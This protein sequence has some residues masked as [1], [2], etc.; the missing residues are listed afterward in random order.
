MEN[1]TLIIPAKYESESLPNVLEELKRFNYRIC[2]V[3]KNT[4]LK[5]INSIKKF[6]IEIIYQKGYGYGNALIEGIN[7]CKTKYFCI[8]NADGSFDP[9]Y[10]SQLKNK[11]LLNQ[12]FVFCSRYEAGG[13]S[14]DDTILTYIGNKFF[15]G[16][17]NLLFKLKITDVLF[18]YVMGSTKAFKE[19][20]MSFNDFSFCIEL[21][22]KAKK[23]NYIL[24]NLPSVERSRKAGIKKV[25][26]FRD[27][28]LILM[29]IIKLLIFKK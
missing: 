25:N 11:I 18:T 23:K 28:F 9:I 16:L 29:S 24:G 8:F 12:D 2:V 27:G 14:E 20:N 21:P 15:T 6:N 13:G 22:I 3:L 4:D 10:L 7:L 17:C 19:L 1:L 26:E 5:T